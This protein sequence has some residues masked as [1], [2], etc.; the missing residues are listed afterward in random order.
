MCIHSFSNT[1]YV[2]HMPNTLCAVTCFVAQTWLY[3]AASSLFLIHLHNLT[4]DGKP[5]IQRNIDYLTIIPCYKQLN[6]KFQLRHGGLA[7]YQ[8]LN[9]GPFMGPVL[10]INKYLNSGWDSVSNSLLKSCWS[11][12]SCDMVCFSLMLFILVDIKLKKFTKVGLLLL[13]KGQST[14]WWQNLLNG[15]Y[16]YH[17]LKHKFPYTHQYHTA[18]HEILKTKA[19]LS[20][21]LHFCQLIVRC[22][23]NLCSENICWGLSRSGGTPATMKDRVKCPCDFQE[24]DRKNW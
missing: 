2:P 15:F 5:R 14:Q 8:C 19:K 11:Q 10:N 3:F 16:L 1:Y 21:T 12:K 13:R 22:H 6:E 18:V 9:Q 17:F 4:N 7:S 23:L 24:E 20:P